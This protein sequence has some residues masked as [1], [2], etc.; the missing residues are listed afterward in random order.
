MIMDFL[1]QFD[2]NPTPIT[3]TAFS[4]NT[5]DMLNARDIAVGTPLKLGIEIITALVGGTSLNIQLLGSPD[6]VTYSLIQE[7]G[8]MLTAVLGAGII[9]NLDIAHRGPLQAIP[10]YYKLQYVVVG[11]YTGGSVAAQLILDRQT[12]TYYPPGIAVLN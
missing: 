10:R 6:N 2:P 7:T 3:A 4:T 12:L 5:L 8:V 11:P 9:Y 1:L